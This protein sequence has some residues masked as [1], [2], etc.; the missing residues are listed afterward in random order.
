MNDTERLARTRKRRLIVRQTAVFGGLTAL[1]VVAGVASYAM[2]VGRIEPVVKAPF[3]SPSPKNLDFG[4]LPCPSAT[5]AQ[6]PTA[7]KVKLNVYNGGEVRLAADSIARTLESR[8]FAPGKVDNSPISFGGSILILTGPKGVN[9][10]YLILGHAPPDAKI[11]LDG[12]ADA[13]IDVIAGDEFEGLRT[14]EEVTVV[15]GQPIDG[16]EGCQEI[17]AIMATMPP[18][19]SASPTPTASGKATAKPK[20][21]AASQD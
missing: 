4:P 10:A 16:L 11:A 20:E 6:Y 13:T 3:T 15:A 21:T 17:E 5:K 2:F 19:P 14:V 9:A 12:R 8:G 7:A 18:A 1:L